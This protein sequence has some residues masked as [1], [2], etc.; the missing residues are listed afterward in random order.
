MKGIIAS[1]A[2]T[3]IAFVILAY[4]LPQVEFSGGFIQL[5]ALAVVFGVVNG[6]IKPIVKLLTLPINLMTLG[7][8]GVVIN[9]VLLLLVAWAADTFFSVGF[10]I[11]GFPGKGLSLDAIIGAILAAIVLSIIQAI[12]GMFVKD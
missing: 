2:V 12:L 5:V 9:G 4:L 10:T 11:G 8:L 1:I 3:A 7:L 6:L